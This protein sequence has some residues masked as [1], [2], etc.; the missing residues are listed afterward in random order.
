MSG[1]AVAA[2][3]P[4][5]SKLR[6]LWS[7]RRILWLLITRDLKVKYA[8]SA[9]GYIWSVLDPLLLAGVYWFIFTKLITRQV[10][11]EPYVVF[12]LCGVLPWQFW[13]GGLRASMKALSAD[14]KLV[15]STNLPREIWILRSVG[16]KMVEFLFSLPV[17]GFFAI[18][19]GAHLTWWV[20]FFPLALLIQVALLVGLGLILAPVS[21]LYSDIGRLLPIVLRLMFYFSPIL[22][23][24]HDVTR[25]LG[26]AAGTVF[27][28]NPLA[29]IL[30][31]YRTAFFNDEW[32]GWG[33]VGVSAG[34]AV[35]TLLVA[36]FLFPRLERV[37]LKEI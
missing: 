34:W 9:L 31:L 19:T 6:I 25:R 30:D 36:I 14:S 28:L 24:V 21:V 32:A 7:R 18:V 8:G 4:V 15:R 17:I 26:G 22:Y 35:V 10:G 1:R 11:E 16:S 33:A 5:Q 27:A 20:L 2:E 29:G 3:A 37:V 23:G 13:N 12:L